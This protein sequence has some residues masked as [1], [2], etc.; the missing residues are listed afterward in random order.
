MFRLNARQ[1]ELTRKLGNGEGS[2]FGAR[3]FRRGGQYILAMDNHYE[4][5]CKV[6]IH[7][8]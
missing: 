6:G 4:R 2:W 1:Q 3:R 7:W 5:V 8:Q